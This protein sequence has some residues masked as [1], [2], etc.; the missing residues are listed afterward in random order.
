MVCDRTCHVANPAILKSEQTLEAQVAGPG[1]ATRLIV[2]TGLAN[3]DLTVAVPSPGGGTATQQAT[4]T[5][6]VGPSLSVAQFRRAVAAVSLASI[7]ATGSLVQHSW[8]VTDVDATFDDDNGKVQ[9]EFDVQ[10]V[11][12]GPPMPALTQG[13]LAS[14][15]FQVTILAA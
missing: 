2:V 10:V 1:G 15:G 5:A 13:L 8:A 12:Q 14:V 7:S 11:V 4:F 3:C 6:H 9:L